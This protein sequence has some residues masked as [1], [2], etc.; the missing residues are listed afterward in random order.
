MTLGVR[1]GELFT[2]KRPKTKPFRSLPDHF[3]FKD[4]MR[5]GAELASE[6]QRRSA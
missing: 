2:Q 6:R 1:V 3:R 5:L 4:V